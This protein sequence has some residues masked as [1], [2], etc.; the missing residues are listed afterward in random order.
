MTRKKTPQRQSPSNV[1]NVKRLDEYQQEK[2]MQLDLFEMLGLESKSYSRT[3]EL[4]DFIPK[5]FWGKVE[6]INGEF[7]RSVERDF[8]CRGK[9]YKV[10]IN[11]ARVQ[12]KNGKDRDYY[13]GQREEAVEDGLR[14]L[15]AEGQGKFLDSQAGVVFTLY[16]LQQTLKQ[17]NH[18]YSYDEIKEALQICKRTT[19]IVTSEDGTSVL[20]SNIFET[21]GLATFEDWKIKGKDAK[22]FVRFNALVTRAIQQLDFRRFNYEKAWSY[23]SVI[24]RQLHKRMSHHYTQAGKDNSYT[25]RL[26]TLIRDFGIARCPQLRDNLKKVKDALEEMKEK[27]IVDKYIVEPVVD[28]KKH[29]K[30]EDA[31]ITLYTTYEFDMEMMEANRSRKNPPPS[32]PPVLFPKR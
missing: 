3:I 11:P 12:G 6:R 16:Q 2:P 25:I 32:P 9:K 5:Y 20:E 8:E 27:G 29:N 15:V 10:R 30:L 19:L 17:A 4:Y 14:K 28:T 21:L 24:A 1:D 7:L 31:K 18:T 13:P 26:N 22:C 23:K